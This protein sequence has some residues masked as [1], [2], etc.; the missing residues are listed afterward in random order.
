MDAS[1]QLLAAAPTGAN[2]DDTNR[3][4]SDRSEQFVAVTGSESEQVNASAMVVAAYSLFWLLA[5][6]FVYLTYRNQARLRT[7]IADLQKQLAKPT[8]AAKDPRP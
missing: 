4:P 6:A 5:V 3:N 8:V 1:K 2:S 7:Q